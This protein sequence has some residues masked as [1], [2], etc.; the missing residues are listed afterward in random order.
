M[1]HEM[2]FPVRGDKL[3]HDESQYSGIAFSASFP[4]STQD[5]SRIVKICREAGDTI[6]VH[7]S[8]TG[9]N[10][11]G[12]PLGGHCMGMEKFCRAAYDADT[13]TLW[14]EAGATF[15]TI[16][17]TVRRESGMTREFPVGPTEK[18]AT[19]GGALSFDTTGLRSFRY[20]PLADYVLEVEFCDSQ[21]EVR[22]LTRGEDGF[23]LLLGSEGMCAVLTGARLATVPLAPA[24]WGLVFFFPSDGAA[25]GFADRAETLPCVSVLEYLDQGCFSLLESYRTSLS[26]VAALPSVPAGQQAAVYLELEGTDEDEIEQATESLIVFAEEA[27]GDAEQTWTAVGDEVSL[28]RALHHAVSECLNM[29]IARFHAAD[30]R[31]KRLS[32]P[33]RLTKERRLDIVKSYQD[34]LRETGLRYVLFGHFGAGRTITLNLLPAST[35]EYLC[36]KELLKQ[37]CCEAARNDGAALQKCGIGKL[38]REIYCQTAPIEEL[39]RRIKAKQKFDPDKV[40]NPGNMFTD[41]VL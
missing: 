27:G 32:C 25:A 5:V 18:T 33:I 23:E 8:L 19:L 24:V 1:K 36:G 13:Q 2:I 31:I 34:S 3:V 38:Y 20:G 14:A 15:Q 6:T 35:A 26:A 11:A 7:G 39:N 17:Q 29:E 37:W 21:G 12:V 4:E 40:F 10:G 28:F 41:T 30:S 22:R 9:M 16:E